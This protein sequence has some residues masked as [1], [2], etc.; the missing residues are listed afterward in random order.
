MKKLVFMAI[1]ILILSGCSDNQ[2]V[3][4]EQKRH[5]SNEEFTFT[6]EIKESNLEENGEIT[7]EHELVYKGTDEFSITHR[8]KVSEHFFYNKHNDRFG[9]AYN[10]MGFV[11]DITKGWSEKYEETIYYMEE[12]KNA[13]R[14]NIVVYV[15]YVS[16]KTGKKVR[17]K[18]E[19]VITSK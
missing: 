11:T 12:L 5:F 7:V 3:E 2:P 6:S 14:N 15:D 18:N 17:L 13:S 1:T 9:P 16:P 4:K 8:G 10:D 19:F